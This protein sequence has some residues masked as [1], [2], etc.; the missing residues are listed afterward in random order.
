MSD[1][2][3]LFPGEDTLQTW[4]YLKTKFYF[5]VAGW[6]S[7]YP[8]PEH[9]GHT[10]LVGLIDHCMSHSES[11]V[12]CYS[13][14]RVPG[15]PSFPVRLTKPVSRFTQVRGFKVTTSF[16]PNFEYVVTSALFIFTGS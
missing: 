1:K 13:R 3:F 12:F 16:F 2:G 15:S 14:A 8:H 7:F 6:F 5:H 10:S 4:G 9:E 11:G